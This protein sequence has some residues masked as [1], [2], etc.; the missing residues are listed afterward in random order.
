M[1][2]KNELEID[3]IDLLKRLLR[4][5]YILGAC[6]VALAIV[7]AAFGYIR[8]GKSAPVQSTSAVTSE[9]NTLKNALSEDDAR[10]A[11]AAAEL[12]KSEMTYY[13]NL[14][15][16]VKDSALMQLDPV[17]AY[18][19]YA[20]YSVTDASGESSVS[21]SDNP[22]AT[23]AVLAE[24]ELKSIENTEEIAKK[25]GSLTAND[26]RLVLVIDA[27]ASN[28]I[29]VSFYSNDEEISK[30][31][32]SAAASKMDKV[33]SKAKETL[34]YDVKLVGTYS[35]CGYDS[36][37]TDKQ[38]AYTVNSSTVLNTAKT[39][40]S[41]LT[42]EQTDYFNY[43]VAHT[44]GTPENVV[45]ETEQA[46]APVKR[47]LNKK[48]I[49][50]GFLGGGFLAV[51]YYS[52]RYIFSN[53]LRTADD[54]NTL[55][56]ISVIGTVNKTNVEKGIDIL[57]AELAL[58][59]SKK[60]AKSISIIGAA[61]TDASDAFKAK[62]ASLLTEKCAGSDIKVIKDVL[63]LEADMKLLADS[64]FAILVEQTDVSKYE[65]IASELEL[66]SKYGVT[67]LGS[68][69]IR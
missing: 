6:A 36:I 9:I 16:E 56:N 22:G 44:D 31:G 11:E 8:S 33:I 20:V 57:A 14:L 1:N 40:S 51:M 43:L 12:Y 28:A 41:T 21:A 38:Y 46:P 55:F 7:A 59:I 23:L 30:A 64:E 54:V 2:Y 68:V 34:D 27:Q 62:L 24:S 17:N 39:I 48:Y 45:I 35:A 3:L 66:C 5:W 29:T 61:A 60:N 10:T 4:K 65:D 63:G 52:L 50:L 69:V 32:L 58:D 19:E 47:S 67:T 25:T 53:R 37:I 15:D 49:L 26:V 18:R 13:H 42:K